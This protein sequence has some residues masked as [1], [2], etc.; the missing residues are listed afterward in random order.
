M[1]RIIV[2]SVVFFSLIFSHGCRQK[3]KKLPGYVRIEIARDS[4]QIWADNQHPY[5]TTVFLSTESSALRE[6]MQLKGGFVVYA[7][8]SRLL[9]HV[10]LQGKDSASLVSD[11]TFKSYLGNPLTAKPDSNAV[12][13]FPFPKGQEYSI[14]QPYKGSFSHNSSFS[15]YAIDFAMPVGDTVCAARDGIVATVVEKHNRGGKS[16]KYRKFA[17]F[18]TLYHADGI[19]TQYVHL[20]QDGSL[21]EYGD[22]VK[23]GQAIGISGMTGFT[24]APHLHF[25]VLKPVS[26]GAVSIPIQ[27]GSIAGKDL[28]KGMKV[29]HE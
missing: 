3:L 24:S 2:I 16:K 14:M 23:A 22:S 5:P 15:L 17:N 11:M 20:Q 13:Q 10:P 28:K 6:H 8:S 9:Y 21:V 12:Y 18:I 26:R 25:N 19:L 4:L 27:F 29:H 1:L 7:D